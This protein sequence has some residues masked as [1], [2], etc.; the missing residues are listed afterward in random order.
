MSEHRPT[1]DIRCDVFPDD[2]TEDCTPEQAAVAAWSNV[3]DWVANGYLPVV[4]VTMHDGSQ[5]DVD[6]QEVL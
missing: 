2:A 5:H 1:V 4:T 6:L 3:K